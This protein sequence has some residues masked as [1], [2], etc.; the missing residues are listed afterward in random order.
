M[1]NLKREDSAK[2]IKIVNSTLQGNETG[3]KNLY[4]K[5]SLKINSCNIMGETASIQS[6]VGGSLN[7]SSCIIDGKIVSS[8]KA[9]ITGCEFKNMGTDVDLTSQTTGAVIYGWAFADGPKKNDNS[10]S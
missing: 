4:S 3:L 8:G 6:S 2:S 10:T 1:P 9:K 5:T 7:V